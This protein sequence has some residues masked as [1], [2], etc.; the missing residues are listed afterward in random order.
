MTKIDPTPLIAEA[1]ARDTAL[2]VALR[3]IEEAERRTARY[4][5]LAMIC[6]L[7]VAYLAWWVLS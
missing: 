4:R 1:Q 5:V 3:K 7:A 2:R 6:A